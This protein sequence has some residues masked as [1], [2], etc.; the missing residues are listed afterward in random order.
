MINEK[1]QLNKII[2]IE[3]LNLY[4]KVGHDI[5]KIFE[6]NKLTCIEA[7]GILESVK[8]AINRNAEMSEK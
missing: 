5:F 2:T 3:R 1:E 4:L 8:F 7:F 6:L